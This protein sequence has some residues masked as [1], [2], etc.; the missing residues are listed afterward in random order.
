MENNNEYISYKKLLIFGTEKTGKTRLAKC[1][2]SNQKDEEKSKNKI[3]NN[4]YIHSFR[5]KKDN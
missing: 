4:I 1:F 2:D 5:I 3:L